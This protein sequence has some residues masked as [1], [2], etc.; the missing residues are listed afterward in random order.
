MI[1]RFALFAAPLLMALTAAAPG[2]RPELPP[3]APLGDVVRVA[4]DTE[5]GTIELDLDH[6]HAPVTT[7]NFVRYVDQKRF[8]GTVFYRAMHLPWG[9]QPNGLI[10]GGT[11]NDPRRT[12]PPIAHEP[13]DLTG[14][15]HKAG[16]ISMAR[17]APGTA[18]GDFSI[19]MAD[20][21][22]LDADPKGSNPDAI[23]GFAA[24]GQVSSGM[25]VVRRIYD[26]PLSTTK[27]EGFMK[28]QM[29]EQP[30]RIITA[31]RVAIAP[32]PLPVPAAN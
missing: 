26:A 32:L 9:D 13:T 18:T 5:L 10:Q 7:E 3:P 8:D 14:V 19:M 29:I 11:Q 27:G 1:A 21:P 12:L 30:V 20:M 15:K 4:L 24:F 23:A 22:G 16:S 25:E 31:R 17:Y 2:K 6:K 28:G